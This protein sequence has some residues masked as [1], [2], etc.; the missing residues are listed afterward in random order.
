MPVTIETLNNARI[1]KLVVS[2]PW[3]IDDLT[4]KYEEEKPLFNASKV[5]VHTLVDLRLMR[6]IPPGALSNRKSPNVTHPRSGQVALVGAN[7]FAQVLVEVAFR[8]VRFDRVVFFDT[9]EEAM[10]YLTALISDEALAT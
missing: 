9:E 3:V 7:A 5:P 6:H 4:S 10:Q 1:V 8:L 2:D